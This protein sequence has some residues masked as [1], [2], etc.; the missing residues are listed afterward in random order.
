MMLLTLTALCLGILMVP[1]SHEASVVSRDAGWEAGTTSDWS[2][3][4]GD[5]AKGVNSEG[6]HD[7]TIVNIGGTY[8]C[9]HTGPGIGFMRTSKDLQTWTTLGPVIPQ[10]PEWL[11]VRYGHNS[12]W[13]PDLLVLGEKVR[14]Y[15]CASNF[16]TNQSVIG[17]AE[18]EKFDPAHP[19]NGW[20]DKGLVLESRTGKE[21]F[22]AIDPEARVDAD[23][24][25][26]LFFGSYF[27]GIYVVEIEPITGM[28]KN[29]TGPSNPHP[30]LPLRART[31]PQGE[32]TES[33]SSSFAKASADMPLLLGSEPPSLTLVARNTADRGNAI[34][35]C[36]VGK[37]GD[38]YYMFVSYGLA[39]Q[40]VRS[41]YRVMVGRSKTITGPYLDR[42]GKSMV[43]GGHTDLLKTSPPMFSPGHCDVFQDADG[44]WL[45]PYHYYD[46]RRY[47]H[48]D[49]WGL[50]TLQVRELLW[51]EDGW[52]MPGLPVEY[53]A[54]KKP[55]NIA[56]A[57]VHQVD[58]G[59]V[60][61]LELKPDGTI[62]HGSELGQWKAD[63]TKLT[64]KWPKKD[65]PGE[66]WF[67]ELTLAYG[68]HYYVGRNNS[69]VIIRGVRVGGS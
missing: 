2:A 39:A 62:V 31:I 43:D 37:R 65:E 38:F 63:G 27:A 68:N 1:A 30:A 3:F 47:W 49:V 41:T 58:F 29:S 57:W 19:L 48:G 33:P 34:E 60:E 61:S 23:G 26:W 51:S 64:L 28:L 6:V 32:A 25:H 24:R 56:G 10:R 36:A 9:V 16:G 13:A 55:V 40:G 53:K 45:M 22:N 12:I 7:P 50:P 21:T 17:L 42:E 20:K 54:E 66:F 15:Y 4:P 69:G 18:C 14:M 5:G 8:F 11:K 67:D 52:P 46:G 35:G 44:K 59:N